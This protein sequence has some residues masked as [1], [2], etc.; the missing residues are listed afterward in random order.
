MINLFDI[1]DRSYSGEK[2]T[3][4]KKWDLRIWSRAVKLVEEFNIKYDPMVAIADVEMADRCFEAAM[5]L[6]SEH[7]VFNIGTKRVVKFDR[8]EIEKAIGQGRDNIIL[9]ENRDRFTLSHRNVD[10][11]NEVKTMA[12]HF[13]CTDEVGP[14]LYQAM[15]EVQSLDMIEGFNFYGE[16]GGRQMQGMVHET[17]GTKYSVSSIRKAIARAG[18]PGMHILYYPVSPDPAVNIAALDPDNGIR[19][20]D[21]IEITP[22]PELKIESNLLAVTI[23]TTEYGAFVNSDTS[24]I[25]YGFGGGPTESAIIGTAMSIAVYLTYRVDYN[26][27]ASSLPVD[28]EKFSL[29]EC[30]WPRSMNLISMARNIKSPLFCFVAPGPEP[31]SEHTWMELAAQTIM[32]V[33]SAAH[34][35]VIRPIRPYRPNLLTPLQIEFCSEI[36][37]AMVKSQMSREEANKIIIND[38]V[39]RYSPTYDVPTKD[40]YR[41]LKGKAFEELYDLNTLKPNKEHIDSY[42]AAKKELTK[43]GIEFEW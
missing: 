3:D 20:T 36:A 30:L 29:T 41:L 22:I 8:E 17:L 40:R 38:L 21:A 39:P 4:E 13:S 26:S 25:M 2:I 31:E 34:I 7:G 35:D 19:K 43:L 42:Y 32:A 24:T 11:F 16:H 14:K 5:M 12:G 10:S 9:G 28:A 6:L 1:L 37:N 18:R 15:A 27:I 23:A 33:A